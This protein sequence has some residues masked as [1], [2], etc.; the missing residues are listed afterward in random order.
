MLHFLAFPNLSDVVPNAARGFLN[1]ILV[2]RQSVGFPEIEFA[3]KTVVSTDRVRII[4]LNKI[5]R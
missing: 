3:L 4:S 1:F 5:S 2:P